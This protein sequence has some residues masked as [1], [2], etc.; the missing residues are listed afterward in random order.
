MRYF[1]SLEFD[2]DDEDTATDLLNIINRIAPYMV[3][4]V[5]IETARIV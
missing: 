1:V 4:N 2:T 5:S 3:D